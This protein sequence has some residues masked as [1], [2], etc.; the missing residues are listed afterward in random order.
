VQIDPEYE[1]LVDADRLHRLAI[2]VLREEG[3]PGPLEL[4]VVVTNDDEVHSLNRDYL[5][6]DYNTDVISFGMSEGGEEMAVDAPTFVTPAER[7]P[8]LGDIAISYDRAAEQAP[9]YGHSTQAEVAMLL[10]H[11][12]LHLLGHDDTSEPER[13][14]MHARQRELLARLYDPEG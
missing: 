1:S 12:L 4:G 9:E 3:T 8:Y 13:E 5:G 11:G 7:P 6:H 2:D 14:R 10:I